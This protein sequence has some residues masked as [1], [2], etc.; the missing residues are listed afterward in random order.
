MR[1]PR[2][3]TIRLAVVLLGLLAAPAG[4]A[5]PAGAVLPAGT[6]LPGP[7]PVPG[8][9]GPRELA[10]PAQAADSTSLSLVGASAQG[11][12]VRQG[13]AAT[14]LVGPPGSTLRQLDEPTRTSSF[15]AGLVELGSVG[16]VSAWRVPGVVWSPSSPPELHR[17]DLAH[18]PDRVIAA[19]ELPDVPVA[20]TANGWIGYADGRLTRHELGPTRSARATALLT[21]LD[22]QPQ[23]AADR[24]GAL[25]AVRRLA[26]GGE[27]V[28]YRVDLV[29]LTSAPPAVVRIA[30]SPSPL[31]EPALSAST[32]AWITTGPDG[33]PV[34]NRRSRSG[35]ATDRYTDQAWPQSPPAVA[36][37]RVGRLVHPASGWALRVFGAGTTS[38]P[39]P[40]PAAGLIGVGRRFYTA[41]G[42]PIGTAG[43]YAVDPAAGTAERVAGVPAQT[44]APRSVSLS[45]G[46]L[47]VAD[48]SRG[49]QAGLTLRRRPLSTTSGP[50]RL[51]PAELLPARAALVQGTAFS[52]A[53]GVSGAPGGGFQLLDR[54]T[55]THTLQVPAADYFDQLQSSGPYSRIGPVVIDA[56]GKQVLDTSSLGA[57]SVQLYGPLLA[58]ADRR[59]VWL[60]D[61]AHPPSATNPVSVSGPCAD[62]GPVAIWGTTVAW[63]TGSA[64]VVRTL[65]GRGSRRVATG[66][67]PSH[68]I[69]AEKSLTWQ[70]GTFSAT[71]SH[72][73]DLSVTTSSPVDLGPAT[74]LAVDGHWLLAE[75]APGSGRYGVR[76]LPFGSAQRPR[77]IGAVVPAT[78]SPGAGAPPWRPAFDTSKP[79]T[80]VELTVRDAAGR[81]VAVR[82]GSGPD[83]SIRDL[84]WDGRADSGRAAPAGDYR[85][86]LTA[87]AQD[88]EGPLSAA[89][90]TGPISGP[91]LL[92]R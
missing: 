1:A 83:G 3:R 30:D 31:S 85:W 10:V 26:D 2:R 49:Q 43:V 90:G 50:A 55:V 91:L 89:D 16:A 8:S 6:V 9:A 76:R 77:L 78:F 86:A 33:R 12:A 39:L 20:T 32:L 69:L 42:G 63:S 87:R 68:L 14:L 34:I 46:Q 15:R 52:A 80:G 37:D 62:C 17:L 21:G 92:R 75:S 5:V 81:V 13:P 45:S 36:G 88:G 7:S 72:T 73:L 23:V 28:S 47:Q 41:V 25:V 40:G 58:F 53:R 84:A 66:S 38:I 24:T 48:R 19:A 65:G 71:T 4:A 64:V 51:G 67:T 11:F 79:L 74:P 27:G 22:E 56:G 18:G 61:L 60:R 59:G 82:T 57:R 35:G 70:T 54:G 44:V 29:D